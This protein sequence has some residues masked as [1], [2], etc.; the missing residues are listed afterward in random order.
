MFWAVITCV[1]TFVLLQ[2]G[3]F[4]AVQ[5]LAILIGLPLA[6]VMFIVIISAIKALK[7]NEEIKLLNKTNKTKIENT[8]EKES[9]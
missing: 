8:Y 6:F 5:V 1:I 4:N 7:D 3:G 9:K 2:V